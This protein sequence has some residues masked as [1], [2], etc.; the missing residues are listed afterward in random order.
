[1]APKRIKRKRVAGKRVQVRI[2]G[3]LPVTFFKEAEAFVAYTPALDL[4][5]YGQTFKEAEAR[6]K[7]AVE[8]FFEE[9]L[10]R[11]TL[12]DALAS[13]GW[14]KSAKAPAGWIPPQVVAQTQIPI[15]TLPAAV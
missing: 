5:S 1:M 7:E 6:F 4:S 11:G 14:T 2:G 8:I 9:C 3:T 15:P 12:N 10:R 13:L